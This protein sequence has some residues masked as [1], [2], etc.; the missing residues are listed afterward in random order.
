MNTF[1]QKNKRRIDEELVTIPFHLT[2]TTSERTWVKAQ[3]KE[4]CTSETSII[5]KS[6]KLY[7]KSLEIRT[8]IIQD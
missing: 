5:R 4:E 6:I 1:W 2:L 8:D 7:K 3:S